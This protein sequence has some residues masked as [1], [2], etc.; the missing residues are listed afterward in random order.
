M[1]HLHIPRHIFGFSSKQEG[2]FWTWRSNGWL[3]YCESPPRPSLFWATLYTAHFMGTLEFTILHYHRWCIAHKL[4]VSVPAWSHH[5]NG[6]LSL[7]R[8]THEFYHLYRPMFKLL[9]TIITTITGDTLLTSSVL[10]Y[11]LGSINKMNT[12]GLTR[13]THEF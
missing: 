1:I 9:I 5:Y 4:C 3:S 13:Q 6:H 2:F 11:Q 12:L 7:T 10:Q 8:Q